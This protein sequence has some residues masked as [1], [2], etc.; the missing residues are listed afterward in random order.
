[1]VTL[2]IV[3]CMVSRMTNVKELNL[4][5]GPVLTNEYSAAQ[6]V[7]YLLTD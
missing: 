7:N 5:N 1:M 6:R 2:I 3:K 4:S